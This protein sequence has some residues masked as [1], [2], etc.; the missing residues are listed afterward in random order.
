M[1][2]IRS[3]FARTGSTQRPHQ[4]QIANGEFELGVTEQELARTKVAGPL[5]DQRGFR[6]P[7][8]AHPAIRW[9]QRDKARPLGRQLSILSACDM[10]AVVAS[11]GPKPVVSLSPSDRKSGSEC[12]LRWLS[13]F[14]RSGRPRG[15]GRSE[16]RRRALSRQVRLAAILSRIDPF[17]IDVDART[18]SRVTYNEPGRWISSTPEAPRPRIARQ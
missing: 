12:L 8:A 13:A 14:K 4:S 3:L 2:A 18:G 7:Q 10:R 9:I 15:T 16:D 1:P 11:T 5:I 17:L 6:S